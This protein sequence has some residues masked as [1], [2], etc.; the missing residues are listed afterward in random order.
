MGATD[1]SD[2]RIAAL[3]HANCIEGARAGARLAGR[4]GEIA[5][6]DGVAMCASGSDFPVMLN[7]AFRLDRS[8]PADRVIDVADEWFSERGRGWSL[9]TTSWADE[10]RDLIDAAG[11]RGLLTVMDTPGMVCDERLPDAAPPDGIE[12]RPITSPPEV[13]AYLA[14]A[15]RAYTSL[16]LPAGWILDTA[17]DTLQLPPNL[18]AIGAFD[19]ETL[20]SGAYVLFSH[21]IAGVYLVATADEARGR[22]L[23]DLVT[24]AVTNVAFDRGVPF[25]TL[26]ASPM[27][28][29]VYRRMGY[30]DVYRY[31]CHTRFA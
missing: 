1:S 13:A 28:E 22:G 21:G 6:R 9:G 7:V 11:E 27:G 18:I 17:P 19:D 16:G 23:A 14:M 24:R 20:L 26:Q 8:V 3:C 15:D 30:R 29:S 12:L 25:V 4:V 5:E 10:E 31:A 2:D